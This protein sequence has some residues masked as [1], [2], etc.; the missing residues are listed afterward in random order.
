M[1]IAAEAIARQQL[2][3]TVVG[4][5]HDRRRAR[6]TAPPTSHT[7]NDR[8]VL[9]RRTIQIWRCR[10]IRYQKQPWL[11]LL[12]QVHTERPYEDTVDVVID[13]SKMERLTGADVGQCD[14]EGAGGPGVQQ[15]LTDELPAR[16]ET[17]DPARLVRGG[18]FGIAL[19]NHEVAS[20]GP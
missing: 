9:Y 8:T 18:I 1:R 19:A 12:R 11:V 3:R 5:V 6:S 17:N 7:N 2:D 15:Q 16:G 4:F 20:G 14:S 10:S 13:R